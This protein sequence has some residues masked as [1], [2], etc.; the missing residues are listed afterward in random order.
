VDPSS[1]GAVCVDSSSG[2]DVLEAL[3]VI[4]PVIESNNTNGFDI[5]IML[6][7]AMFWKILSILVI[8]IKSSRVA[9]ITDKRAGSRHGSQAMKVPGKLVLS[10]QPT[11]NPNELHDVESHDENSYEY[12]A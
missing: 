6:A 4:F 10:K 11:G 5:G 8:L 9:L 1:P 3:G 7:I 12:G 2:K